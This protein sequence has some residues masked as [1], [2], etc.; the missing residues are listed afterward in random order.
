MIHGSYQVSE[1]SGLG[2]SIAKG[3]ADMI[4]WNIRVESELG[5]GSCFYFTVPL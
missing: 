1:G 4:G 5:V 3:M 2:L